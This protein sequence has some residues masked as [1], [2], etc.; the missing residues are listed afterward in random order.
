MMPSA[1]SPPRDGP[2]PP[3]LV[4]REREQRLLRGHLAG[5]S[6]GRGRLVLVGGSAGI[7]KTTLISA[8]AREAEAQG[9]LVLG[10]ACYDL[11]ATPP[12]G[13]WRDLAAGYRPAA[14]FPPLPAVLTDDEPVAA[15]GPGTLFAQV[16]EFLIA[17]AAVRPVLV[18]LEW[19][20][21]KSAVTTR[22]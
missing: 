6:A 8:M 11:T 10:G 14:G 3:L 16:R 17:L 4:G 2:E 12:Y 21:V 9:F 1:V 22:Q 7:G 20:D 19:T 13:P 18:V 15:G 5:S